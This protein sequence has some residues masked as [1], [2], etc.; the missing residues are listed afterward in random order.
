MSSEDD[1]ASEF[2][3]F[4]AD[5]VLTFHKWSH[6][7][8]ETGITPQI[9]AISMRDMA[10]DLEAFSVLAG[11]DTG[12]CF[13]ERC[14]RISHSL[15]A[16]SKVVDLIDNFPLRARVSV[17]NM[18]NVL[19]DQIGRLTLHGYT[20]EDEAAVIMAERARCGTF[21]YHHRYNDPACEEVQKTLTEYWEYLHF[22]LPGCTCNNCKWEY[23]LK[24]ELGK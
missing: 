6:P 5:M 11:K 23:E 4:R 15:L 2:T 21:R 9:M 8:V 18:F 13:V 16:I 20:E 24:N 3:Q 7:I 12:T 19:A 1:D 22:Y 10:I 17:L 14:E